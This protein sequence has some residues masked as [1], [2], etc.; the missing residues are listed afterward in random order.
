MPHPPLTR[1]QVGARFG[2]ARG[3][4]ALASGQAGAGQAGTGLAGTGLAGTGLAGTGQ[5]GTGQAGA[6]VR[7]R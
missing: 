3:I 1:R 6:T 4:P 7:W 2:F 5:A